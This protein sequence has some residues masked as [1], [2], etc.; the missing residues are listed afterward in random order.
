MMWY[1]ERSDT[2]TFLMDFAFYFD[3][4]FIFLGFFCGSSG[5]HC[6]HSQP[7]TDEFQT[8]Q[9]F[10]GFNIFWILTKRPSFEHS[11]TILVKAFLYKEI[12]L[13]N[14]NLCVEMNSACLVT[15]H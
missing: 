9:G 11:G 1:Q 5:S 8:Q 7:T 4:F 6:F 15:R 13:G 14:E 2:I 3:I 12:Q 10:V